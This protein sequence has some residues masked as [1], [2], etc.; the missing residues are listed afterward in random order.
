MLA[1]CLAGEAADGL[2]WWRRVKSN[3]GLNG[4]EVIGLT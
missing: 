3:E 4:G 1:M 2:E